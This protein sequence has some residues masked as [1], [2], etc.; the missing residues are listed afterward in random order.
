[1]GKEKIDHK[2]GDNLKM[3]MAIMYVCTLHVY[4]TI[5]D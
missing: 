1:M 3:C 2:R 5:L 4:M